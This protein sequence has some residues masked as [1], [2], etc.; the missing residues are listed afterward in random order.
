MSVTYTI[1]A[2]DRTVRCAWHIDTSAALPARLAPGLHAS[3]PRVGL[4]CALP[5]AL[6]RVGWY[7]CGPHEA[8]RD[9][10]YSAAVRRYSSSVHDMHVPYIFPQES[11]GRADV[12]WAAVTPAAGGAEGLAVCVAG[13]GAPLQLSVSRFSAEEVHRAAHDHE[14]VADGRVHLHLDA[15]HMGVGGDDSW[16]P[17]VHEQYLV[18]PGRHAFELLLAPGAGPERAA[19]LWRAEAAAA[20]AAA[21]V[22]S[23]S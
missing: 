3:L 12:R 1:S 23:A 13:G 7:G 20:A 4:C 9:R 10:K 21:A 16:S 8:Y 11:G 2:A 17:S 19:Q 6:Q 15:A 22:G 5:G 14:L 18:P